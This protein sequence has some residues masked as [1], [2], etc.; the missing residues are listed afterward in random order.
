MAHA[1][2]GTTAG[3]LSFLAGCKD[4][5]NYLVWAEIT[6]QLGKLRSLFS[7]DEEIKERLKKFT[8]R[9]VSPMVEKL[10][11]EAKEGEDYLTGRMRSLLMSTAGTVGHTKVIEEA[12]RRFKLYTSGEDR[13]SIPPSLRLVCF[14]IAVAEGGQS[15]LDA[16]ISEYTKT[17]TIDGKEICLSSLGRA[18]KPELIKQVLELTLSDKVKTQDKHTPAISMSNN[19]HARLML[20]HFI[21]ENWE[22]VYK[23]LSGNMVVLDRFLKMSLNKFASFEVKEDIEAFFKEKDNQGYDK[24]LNIISDSIAGNAKFVEREQDLVRGWLKEHVA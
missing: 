19:S 10:G 8:L 5:E 12:Q 6:E 9:L 24:G 7:E 1:G 11:W 4:E 14:R 20:W 18:R 15:E 13:T 3:L 21:K 17:T 16:V 23:Q 22:T 2:L